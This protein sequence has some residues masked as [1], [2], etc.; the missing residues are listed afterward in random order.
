MLAGLLV[1][2]IQLVSRTVLPAV[3]VSL[4]VTDISGSGWQDCYSSIHR[5]DCWRIWLLV[6]FCVTMFIFRYNYNIWNRRQLM[7]LGGI[8]GVSW[9][10]FVNLYLQSGAIN[11][12]GGTNA[13]YWRGSWQC[14]GYCY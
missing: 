4:S 3:N 6:F 10:Y 1:S 8:A 7:Y 13:V 2:W 9:Y 5:R 14:A 12:T 11:T